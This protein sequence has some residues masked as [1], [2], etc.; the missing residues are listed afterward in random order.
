MPLYRLYLYMLYNNT[1]TLGARQPTTAAVGGCCQRP[2]LHFLRRMVDGSATWQERIPK[3][4]DNGPM[5]TYPQTGTSGI[6]LQGP[7]WT[8]S[9][10]LGGLLPTYAFGGYSNLPLCQAPQGYIVDQDWQL[11]RNQQ[12][13]HYQLLKE[14]ITNHGVAPTL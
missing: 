10:W 3:I 12:F 4:R 9:R 13:L 2:L 7:P 5:Y 11:Q 8:K 6:I 14:L 1:L